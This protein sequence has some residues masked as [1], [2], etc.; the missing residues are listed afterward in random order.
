MLAR[1]GALCPAT[2]AG[3]A[4]RSGNRVGVTVM[5]LYLLIAAVLVVAIVVAVM[6]RKKT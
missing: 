1:R 4:S 5:V 2:P 6:L 3:R